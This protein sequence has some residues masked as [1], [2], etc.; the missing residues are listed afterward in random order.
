MIILDR[1]L[2]Y[3]D[4]VLSKNII[5]N[6]D[7]YK[8]CENFK[9]D[10]EVRQYE[11]D[12]FFC[13]DDKICK[14]ID[15]LL[16]LINYATGFFAGDKVIDHIAG[17]QC[18]LIINL[19]CWRY[20][21]N[22]KKC[23][24]REAILFI[25]RKNGK[26][27]IIAI[28]FILLILLEQ[29]YSE[30]YSGCLNKDLAG[31]VRKAMQQTIDCSPAL[32]KYFKISKMWTG[33]IECKITHSFFQPRVSEANKNNSI[34]PSSFVV[35]EFGAFEDK[36]LYEAFKSGQK[37][38]INPIAFAATTAYALTDS[39]MVGELDYAKRV[40]RGEV[41][42]DRYFA[43]LYYAEEEHMW[44]DI[45]IYQANPL[46]IEENYQEIREHREKAK[47]LEDEQEE[48][49]T[50]EMNVMQQSNEE[51]KYLNINFWNKCRTNN[52]DFKGRHVVLGLD[53]SV[54]NDLTAVGVMFKDGDNY[55]C[56]SHGFKPAIDTTNRREKFNYKLAAKRGEVTIC[57]GATVSYTMVKE[58]IESIEE[59]GTIIDYIVTDPMNAKNLVE[60][61]SMEYDVI[62]LKQTFTNLSPATKE[63]RKAVYEGRMFYEA[64]K[65]LDW[66]MTNAV[67]HK[68]KSDDE[69]LAKENKNKQR[70]DMV[71][72][73]VFCMTQ[74]YK[75]EPSAASYAEELEK[76]N[77]WNN[78]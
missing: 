26:T 34:R 8:Q 25:A 24:Y 73:L 15:N 67:T 41:Q 62:L 44:D 43:L 50:K 3:V 21:S 37:N 71:A 22:P 20:K 48:Y 33:K 27:W 59:A 32:E 31:E 2:K 19:L 49:L 69:M 12:C 13:F 66:N 76:L 11:D 4:D 53:L 36:G 55:Y 57:P 46:E 56:M 16:K 60:E 40:V 39:I 7:V 17:F 77:K 29:D 63:F 68:G 51:T 28:I 64:N 18:F 54:T 61:L 47:I 52:I 65:A 14:R 72:V 35:D 42:N 70:I 45:G 6:Q 5:T 1:A 78:L 23:R 38:V 75:D 58:Y 74:L 10:Y 30:F 9:N